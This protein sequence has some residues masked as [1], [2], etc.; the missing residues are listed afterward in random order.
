MNIPSM[1]DLRSIAEGLDFSKRYVMAK[2][3]DNSNLDIP[4]SI[5][6]LN[7]SLKPYASKTKQ[8]LLRSY[9]EKEPPE[10]KIESFASR[11]NPSKRPGE[12]ETKTASPFQGINLSTQYRFQTQEKR[13]IN[14]RSLGRRSGDRGNEQLQNSREIEA[15]GMKNE[16][17]SS[18][19]FPSI[20]VSEESNRDN[21]RTGYDNL[22]I[23]GSRLNKEEV[24]TSQTQSKKPFLSSD[25]P[26]STDDKARYTLEPS[27]ANAPSL[28]KKQFSFK[29]EQPMKFT[30]SFGQTSDAFVKTRERINMDEEANKIQ[31]R[32][33][34]KVQKKSP[35]EELNNNAMQQD[36]EKVLTKFQKQSSL[37]SQLVDKYYANPKRKFES[38]LGGT[39]GNLNKVPTLTS[40]ITQNSLQSSIYK[41]LQLELSRN[42]T[43]PREIDLEKVQI[44]GATSNQ[45]PLKLYKFKNL[46]EQG[47]FAKDSPLDLYENPLEV[48]RKNPD[49]HQNIV[50]LA[51]PDRVN[52]SLNDSAR[53]QVIEREIDLRRGKSPERSSPVICEKAMSRLLQNKELRTLF[54]KEADRVKQEIEAIKEAMHYIEANNIESDKTLKQVT[55]KNSVE[56]HK[57]FRSKKGAKNGPVKKTGIPFK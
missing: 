5:A 45:Q 25:N 35:E 10:V 11:V 50:M 4:A 56:T 40:K 8:N 2:T 9:K 20:R 34:N 30:D 24:L 6:S 18:N 43:N 33:T 26:P 32:F 47:P 23:D 37:Q 53:K 42:L 52:R 49:F 14:F 21:L 44:V 29:Q 1:F 54:F 38:G 22:K 19:L 3:S 39:E 13:D 41:R 17:R 55:D 51:K 57:A 28:T 48:V 16:I 7:F 12:F 27:I 31:G 36:H 46:P 15:S